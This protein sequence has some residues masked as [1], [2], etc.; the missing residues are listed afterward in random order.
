[1][2]I[3]ERLK[4][5]THIPDERLSE[6][7]P[8]P[9]SVKI[10][11]TS[12]CN[13]KCKYCAIAFRNGQPM[14]D[15][16]WKLFTRITREMKELGVEEIGVF[17]IGE[18]FMNPRY[19]VNAIQFL[20]RVLQ[21]PYVFLTSNAS[22]AKPEIVKECIES[23]LDSLKWS[24]NAADEEQFN[25]LM[26]TSTR[27]FYKARKNIK[28]A[29]EIRNHFYPNGTRLY[30]SSIKYDDS[31]SDRMRFLLDN[32]V[33]PYVDEHYWLP[34]YTAGG[35]A[36]E[37]EEKLGMQP[38]AGNTGRLDDPSEPIPC[39]TLFTAAHIMVDGRMTACCL[40][41]IGNWVMGDLTKQSF[42]EVWHSE[43]FK[44]L[45]RAHL[46]KNIRGTKCEQC[47]LVGGE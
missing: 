41:G 24:C 7:P 8:V 5:I 43:D 12:R 44:T 9:K 18:A 28:A 23:G 1:M 42:M 39:W 22:L 29:Y 47:A 17:Y 11:L 4:P 33:K 35:Q 38:I 16:D 32:Y 10:E 15:M 6:T 2:S 21:I 34:L 37:T 13:Y 30:A 36:R 19:L 3:A 26:G 40:D 46:A 31:Q 20:K 25:R 27:L 45:R 14:K